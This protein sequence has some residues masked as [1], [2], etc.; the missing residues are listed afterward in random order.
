MLCVNELNI[1]FLNRLISLNVKCQIVMKTMT[2]ANLSVKDDAFNQI[3]VF[4][5]QDF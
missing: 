2:A 1:S 5:Q 3:S 4:V